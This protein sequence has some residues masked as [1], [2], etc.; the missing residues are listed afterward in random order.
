MQIKPKSK[1]RGSHRTG[2]L[3]NA[4]VD[5]ITKVLGFK[6]NVKDDP[7]KVVNSWGFE[8][9]GVTC[10]IWDYN[11]SHTIGQFS[12]YGPASVFIELFGADRVS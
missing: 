2:T 11:G 9:D 7:Y 8:A 5:E 3:R 1:I 10:A 4:S 12:T 6:S